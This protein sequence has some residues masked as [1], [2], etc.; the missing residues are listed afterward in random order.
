[1]HIRKRILVTGGSGFLG[2]HLCLQLLNLGHDI[3]CVDNFYTGT[4]DNTKISF[5]S[6]LSGNITPMI[7]KP[8]EKYTLSSR[9]VICMTKN[10]KLNT[11]THSYCYCNT[12]VSISSL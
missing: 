8:G 5:A 11:V 3:L 6:Y 4:K 12:K 1:M 7:I 9:S 2:S 10:I